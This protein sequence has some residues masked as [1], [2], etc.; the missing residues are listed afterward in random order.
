MS[1]SR[2]YGTLSFPKL[3]ISEKAI[4][5]ITTTCRASVMGRVDSIELIKRHCI[6]KRSVAWSKKLPVVPCFVPFIKKKQSNIHQCS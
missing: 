1:R 5:D 4:R 2:A 6:F 3:L